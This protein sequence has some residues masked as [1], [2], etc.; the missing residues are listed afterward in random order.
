MT[1][2]IP[3]LPHFMKLLILTQ[4]VDENNPI[5]GFFLDWIKEFVKHCESVIVICLY[6]GQYD[7]P[8]N[9]RV[10]SLGKE[11]GVSRIKYLFRFYKYI[12][13]ERSNYDS[14]FVHMN[15]VY[16]I[17]GGWFWRIW[18]KKIGLWYVHKKVSLSLRLAEKNVDVIFTAS[19]ES[20][21]IESGKVKILGHGI[22]LVNFYP[23]N[24]IMENRDNYFGI[25]CVGRISRIKNQKLLIEALDILVNR[26][27]IKNIR[28]RLLGDA[29]SLDDYEY[30]KE[31]QLLIEGKQLENFIEFSGSVPNKEIANYY[32]QADLSVNLCP[33][34]GLDKAVLESIVCG[35]PVIV[36]NK[37]F[38]G[39]F[40]IY[41]SDLVLNSSDPDDLTEKIFKIRAM[42][43]EKKDKMKRD[44]IAEVKSR[45]SL[46]KLI[47]RIVAILKGN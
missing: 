31:L 12:W 29:T 19:K 14:A 17:L 21:G 37:T 47:F 3:L 10:L 32:H 8:A 30:K 40:G 11:D 34:G 42:A 24:K 45:H 4:A 28:I 9:V 33:T 15:Q 43:K 2:R 44:L 20:F 18:H 22:N 35:V 26:E 16:V 27:S 46:E 25:V 41:S 36:L 23:D 7:L 13:Q 38:I 6:K 1:G 5:L 39:E